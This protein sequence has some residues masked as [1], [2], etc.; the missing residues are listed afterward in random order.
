MKWRSLEESTAAA[1]VRLLREQLAER[2]A[3]ADAY[4]RA[5]TQAVHARVVQQLRDSGILNRVLPVGSPAPSF[6]LEDQ[7]GSTVSSHELLQSGRLIVIFFRGRWCPFCLAQ[8]QAMSLVLPQIKH[9]G[10]SLAAISPQK[11][12][13]SSFMAEQHKLAFPLLSDAGNPVARKFGLI[14]RVP[15]DQQDVYRRAFV[16]VPF[17]NGDNSWELPIPATF[18]VERDGSVLY[19]SADPDY[20]RRPEPAELLEVLFL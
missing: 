10:A 8:L 3:L 6:E 15:E 9:S 18:I 12:S 4:V 16:N 20:T 7:N 5:E 17:V 11:V 13:Q 19:T 14:Y 1:D 2:K